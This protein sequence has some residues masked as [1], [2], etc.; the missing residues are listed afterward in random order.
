[1]NIGI[2]IRMANFTEED[3]KIRKQILQTLAT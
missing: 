2:Y 1:M 3:I